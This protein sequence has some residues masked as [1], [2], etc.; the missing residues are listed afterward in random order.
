M[1]TA[2]VAIFISFFSLFVAAISLGWN[3]Y[4]DLQ[5]PRLNVQFSLNILLG[6]E[7]PESDD[8]LV[9]SATNLGSGII[10]LNGIILK[11]PWFFIMRI[12]RKVR[13]GFLMHD[14][15]NPMSAQLPLKLE[16]GDRGDFL[17]VYNKVCF[18][19]ENFVNIGIRD[20]F[21]RVHLAPKK[22]YK[23]VKKEFEKK[24]KN[25]DDETS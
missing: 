11:R 15:R 12:L 7:G 3:I 19:K 6:E 2:D 22:Q 9:I 14:Y 17:L 13:F 24:F 4:R 23:M 25:A 8:N 10:K 16:V 18:L 20:S 1:S 5:R 21:G